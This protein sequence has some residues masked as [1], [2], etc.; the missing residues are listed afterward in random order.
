M[1]H[2]HVSLYSKSLFYLASNELFCKIPP[3][4]SGNLLGPIFIIANTFQPPLV[5][6]P[7]TC[8]S[9]TSYPHYP[10]DLQQ[11]YS[12]KIYFIINTQK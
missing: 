4:S 8:T 2:I 10:Q 9:G 6:S 12:R 11:I 3:Q 5:S 1:V 7:W